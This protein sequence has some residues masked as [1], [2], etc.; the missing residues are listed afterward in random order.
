MNKL[1]YGDCLPIMENMAEDTIDLI[2]LDPPFNSNRSY[3]AIYKDSTGLELPKQIEAFCDIWQLTPEREQVITEMPILMRKAGIDDSAAELWKLWMHALRETQP[4][5]LAYLSYMTERL[6]VMKRLLKNSGSIYLHCDP[7]ASHYIKIVMDAI[8]GH[9]NFRNEIIW[10]RNDGRGKGSQFSSR[11]FGA[12]TDTIF[13]YTQSDNYHFDST[14]KIKDDDSQILKKF[15]KID[16][17]GRKYYIGIP[18]FRSQSM[19]DR[20]NLCYEWRGFTNPHPSG[21]R[22]NK[23][24]L[25]EEYQK[26]NIVIR[27]DGKL[28]R[29]KYLED[30]QGYPLDNN[31]TDIPRVIGKERLGYPTQKPVALLKRII[32]ASS[33]EG[34]TVLDPFCGGATTICAA[35]EL[36]RKW[37]GIDIAYHAVRRVVQ[38]R[39]AD[40]KYGLIEEVH[41]KIDGIPITKEAATD[42]WNRDKYQFQCWA[43]ESVYGFVSAKKSADGGIDGRIYFSMPECK[44]LQSMVLEVK[45]GANVNIGIVRDLRGALERSGAKMAGLSDSKGRFIRAEA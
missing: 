29:R 18:I 12:N 38:A 28:E 7:T 2:Y 24:R 15:N 17:N 42:L 1:Y 45:G 30:Y 11:K 37:I 5:L 26:G 40:A 4:N 25:E 33:N 21:W 3:N 32:E 31:W 35:H 44:T 20:P 36:N 19:G 8:F 13:F 41:Y 9:Q 10:Q 22:L 6:L 39:L 27:Q 43:V 14:L 34:D 23:D 16:E